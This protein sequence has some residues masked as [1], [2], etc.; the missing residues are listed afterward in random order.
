MNNLSLKENIDSLTE[1]QLLERVKEN[2]TELLY[3]K[4]QR[5]NLIRFLY[6]T[7]GLTITREIEYMNIDASNV[8]VIIATAGGGKTTN[9]VAYAVAQK[10]WRKSR[11]D[12]DTTVLGSK[13]LFLVYNKHNVPDIE[14]KHRAL[15]NKLYSAGIEDLN[16]DA[17]L[18]VQTMHSMC[19]TWSKTYPNVFFTGSRALMSSEYEVERLMTICSNTVFKSFDIKDNKPSDVKDLVSFYNYLK[20]TLTEIDDMESTPKFSEMR[21]SKEVIKKVFEFYETKKELGRVC[22][23]V[24]YLVDFRRVLLTDERVRNRVKNYYETIVADEVQDFTPIMMDIL[25]LIKGDDVPMTLIGD[26]DQN[27]YSFK[28]SSVKSLINLPNEF[29]DCKVFSLSVNRRCRSEILKQAKKVIDLNTIRFEKN[30]RALNSGGKVECVSYHSKEGELISVI[31]HLK[32][33]TVEELSNTVIAYR[34]TNSSRLLSDMLLENGI[35]FN[36]LSGYMPLTHELYKHMEDLMYLALLPNKREYQMNLY[37]FTPVDKKF[38]EKLLDYSPTMKR[39]KKRIGKD[40]RLMDL[41]WEGR[42]NNGWLANILQILQNAN[43]TR[44]DGS[45][46][47]VSEWFP[48]VFD[49]FKR[50]YWNYRMEMNNNRETDEYYTEKVYEYFNQDKTISQ[51]L[52]GFDE[53]KIKLQ[54]VSDYGIGVTLSTFHKLKGLEYDRVFL[55][56]LEDSIFPNFKCIEQREGSDEL[57][58]ELMECENRLMYVAMTRAK[59]ELYLYYSDAEPSFYIGVI[60]RVGADLASV[61]IASDVSRMNMFNEEEELDMDEDD[62][63]TEI[64]SPSYTPNEV[65][66][67]TPNETKEDLFIEDDED[68]TIEKVEE[69]ST[70]ND[71]KDLF[72]DD[73]DDFISD[74]LK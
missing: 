28:G 53:L 59:D 62:D 3:S 40:T 32:K 13:M 61:E 65:P 39:F 56:D 49:A 44:S 47:Y 45:V 8:K 36:V 29:E 27:I 33:L 19:M 37:K 48:Q 51:L 72:I 58:Q 42:T 38:V 11:I 22:D 12:E 63:V 24:D 16:I 41:P 52:D 50:H 57:K 1:K 14:S 66:K 67:D 30:I 6:N 55:I 10:I 70:Y 15:V 20:E 9:T 54:K 60:N 17:S 26:E 2:T 69:P 71:T 46:P 18:Q 73:E 25:R 34:N 23:F 4:K 21:Y 74:F 31:N 43:V 5:L 35:A 64:E 68:E 7:L